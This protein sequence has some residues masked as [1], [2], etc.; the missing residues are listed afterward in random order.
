MLSYE[1]HGV[2]NSILQIWQKIP[3]C[4][5]QVMI[6]CQETPQTL[7][8]FVA[9]C[10]PHILVLSAQIGGGFSKFLVYKEKRKINLSPYTVLR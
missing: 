8:Y 1:A 9:I 7:E 2:S 5:Q 10:L 3:I 6:V 4:D